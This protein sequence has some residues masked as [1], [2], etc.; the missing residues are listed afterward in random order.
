MDERGGPAYRDLVAEW[1]TVEVFDADFPATRWRRA[2][3]DALIEAAVTNGAS[4]WEWHETR[5]GVV[6]ELLFGTDEQLDRFRGLPVVLAALDAVPDRVRGLAV[7]RGRGGGAGAAV[8][9]R[10]RPA[11]LTAAASLPDPEPEEYVRLGP[12]RGRT[13]LLGDEGSREVA[14]PVGV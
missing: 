11:P 4:N 5:W 6:L 13:E 9:R 1:L 7:Y 3:E 8:P 14:P 12:E 2:H 10:P